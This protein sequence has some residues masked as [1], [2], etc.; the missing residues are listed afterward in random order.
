MKFKVY[1]G[2]ICVYSGDLILEEDFFVTSD[3][4]FEMAARKYHTIEG[5]RFDWPVDIEIDGARKTVHREVK[6]SFKV[7]KQ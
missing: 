6:Y 5:W 7:E 1:Q 2:N 3:N 4:L